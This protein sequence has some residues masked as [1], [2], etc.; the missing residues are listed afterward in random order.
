MNPIIAHIAT[1]ESVSIA[2]YMELALLH[3]EWGYYQKEPVFGAGGDFIT[4]PEIS[5]IFGEMMG[6]WCADLWIKMG[7]PKRFS[8]VELGPGRGTL[9]KDLLRAT[10]HVE[11]F[12]AA[13]QIHLV[14]ASKQLRSHQQHVIH[15]PQLAWHVSVGTL[16]HAPSIVLANEF[17][18]ALPIE[19]YRYR[20]GEWFE[21]RIS[22]DGKSLKLRDAPYTAL[23]S[24]WSDEPQED[25]IVE[26]C[27]AAESIMAALAERILAH[28]G[29]LLICDYGYEHG[30]RGDT[31]QAVK[32]HTYTDILDAPGQCDL[33]AHVD[34]KRL[35]QL[36]REGGLTASPIVS[37]GDFLI[38]LGALERAQRLSAA[39]GVHAKNTILDDLNRL[40]SPVHM[41]TL[42]KVLATTHSSLQPAGFL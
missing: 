10:R 34:F 12:H 26:R 11:G 40:V 29:G 39:L 2:E 6:I 15:H 23:L 1:R 24:G 30:S 42:F 20:G 22:S 37:Q 13:A 9:M 33:T 14:E 41:G 27:V 17:F 8:L 5:Q 4:A 18:D 21:R 16:P 35:A 19:Q 36:A 25:V 7:S 28:G 31:L 32:A 38:R 3:P